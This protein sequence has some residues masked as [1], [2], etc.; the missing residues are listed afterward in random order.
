ML[1][2]GNLI[3]RALRSFS[4]FLIGVAILAI[5]MGFIVGISDINVNAGSAIFIGIG[6]AWL[7]YFLSLIVAA[8]AKMTE[9]AQEILNS[10]KRKAQEASEVELS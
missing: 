4:K 5:V 1:D 7:L 8:I 9:A 10:S 6:A 3:A 2:D